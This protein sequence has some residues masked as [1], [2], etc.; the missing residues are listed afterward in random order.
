MLFAAQNALRRSLIKATPMRSQS[1][2][3]VAKVN[4]A[5]LGV[6]GVGAAV[7]ALAP[8]HEFDDLDCCNHTHDHKHDSHHK[9]A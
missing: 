3:S 2:V 1:T 4:R 8:K 9:D 5:A 7:I 6:L